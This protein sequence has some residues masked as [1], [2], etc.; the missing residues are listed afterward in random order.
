[1]DAKRDA[2]GHFEKGTPPG[3]GRPPKARELAYLAIAKE[4]V[5]L[6]AWRRIVE[7][8]VKDATD[9][10]D[11]IARNHGRRFLAEYLI[12]KP[13]Q[14]IRFTRDSDPFEDFAGLSDGELEAIVA[15]ESESDSGAEEKPSD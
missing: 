11:P 14:A 8:A 6:D 9:G 15:S 10:E 13:P 7:G 4:I 5:T 1:V 12:G 3:P 2:S